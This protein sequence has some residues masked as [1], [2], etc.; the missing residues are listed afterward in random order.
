MIGLAIAMSPAVRVLLIH[1][2]FPGQYRHLAPAL[3]ARGD[4]L[5]AIGAAQA[6][7]LD[8]VPLRRYPLPKTTPSCHP[9][10]ADFQ[11]KC[12]RAQAVARLASQCRDEG[13]QPDLVIGHPGWGELLA[14]KDVFPSTPVLHQLEWVYTLTGGD[15][16]FDPEFPLTGKE[17]ESQ[18]RLRRAPQLLAFHDLD[19]AW[20]P[21]QWQAACAPREFRDRVSVIHEGIDTQTI[22]P[23]LAAEVRL[24]RA[25]LTLR[26]GDEVLTFVARNLE[27]YRG[28]HVFMRLLP[29][30]QRRRPNLQ[31]VVVGAD[32]VSYGRPPKGG[33]TWRQVL[34]KEVGGALA[35]ERLHFVG[36]VPLSVLHNLFQVCRAHAYFTYPF[37]LSWSLLEAMA[38]GALVVGSATPPLREVI[39][40][41]VNGHLVDFFD[42]SAWLDTLEKVL[43]EPERQH[44][45][46]HRAR[47][48]IVEGYDLG[49]HCL[50]QQLAL[51][52]QVA[53][54]SR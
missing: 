28:F 31:V 19:H 10:A 54:L 18:L 45:L 44:P 29:E 1:Q 13:F 5:L 27:P 41:G 38:C 9:W 52:D 26:P 17:A 21:T 7:G 50:P 39:E 11:T 3:A 35:M 16:N 49:S 37:V 14:I 12:V 47:Q 22:T 32:G 30:L 42:Q 8:G 33:G 43:A 6:P 23:N 15:T 51:V 53:R 2:N 46:R 48:T 24:Q 20:A 4:Q 34:L 36:R 40:D 25:G